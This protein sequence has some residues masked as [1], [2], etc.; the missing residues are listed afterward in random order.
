MDR[1]DGQRPKVDP[2]TGEVHD[3]GVAPRGRRR[4]TEYERAERDRVRA[5]RAE[6]RRQE[7]EA[8]RALNPACET[9]DDPPVRWR[10]PARMGGMPNGIVLNLPR[11]SGRGLPGSS[12]VLAVRS[13]DGGGPNGGI[14]HEHASA[15]IMFRDGHGYPRRTEGVAIHRADGRAFVAAITR[16]LD[17]LDALESPQ[18]S[19]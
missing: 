14:A 3:D 17:E 9:Q 10:V 13:Y 15:F 7:I 5:E 4:L 11:R 16:W 2:Q 1:D 12:L 8:L 19:P 18:V 6:L